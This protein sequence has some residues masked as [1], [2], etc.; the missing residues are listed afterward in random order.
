MKRLLLVIVCALIVTSAGSA[1]PYPYA[2]KVLMPREIA[3]ETHRYWSNYELTKAIAVAMG[4]SAGSLGAWHDNLAPDGW[5]LLSRDCGLFQINLP[6]SQVGT[7]SEFSLRTEDIS[8]AVWGPVLRNNVD[9]A[10][11]LYTTPWFRN[12]QLDM[13]RWQPWVAY[14]TGWATF[15]EFWV[16]HQDASGNPVGP[17]LRT[18]RYIQQA[19]VGQMNYHILILKDWDPVAALYYGRRYA[20][21][22]G[23]HAKLTITKYGTLAFIAPPMPTAP[24]LDGIGPRPIPNDGS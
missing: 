14:T 2:G 10:Y 24:P 7:Q 21:H 23:V 3:A 6:A 5:T 13:R 20:Y 1:R 9:H 18:G 11:A 22:F 12:D 16:W 15:P 4:E 17:W 8:P 19:I